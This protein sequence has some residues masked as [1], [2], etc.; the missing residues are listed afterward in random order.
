MSKF[1]TIEGNEGVGKSTALTFIDSYLTELNVLHRLTR[2]PGGTPFAEKIRDLLVAHQGETVAYKTEL[3]LF[4][5]A[6]SQHIEA[7]IKPTLASG[8]WVICDRFTDSSYAYQGAGRGIPESEIAVLE[9]WVQQDFQPDMTIL[10]DAPVELT[11]ARMQKRGTLDR[12][13]ASQYTFFER[14]RDCY[15]ERAKRYSDR[16]VVIDASGSLTKV[17]QQ[18]RVVLDT[19]CKT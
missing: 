5:A 8:A 14:I 16:Y 6:R 4:F 1:I 10:L 17:Q 2:E 11:Y 13:E 12:I 3:L 9:T 18:L 15:L 7:F 19:L